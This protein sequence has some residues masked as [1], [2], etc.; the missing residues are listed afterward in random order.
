MMTDDEIL[1]A[2]RRTYAKGVKAVPIALFWP[3]RA[4][5]KQC[6]VIGAAL[7][8]MYSPSSL[9]E[10]SL[11][12]YQDIAKAIGRTKKFVIGCM[13]GFDDVDREGGTAAGYELGQRARCEFLEQS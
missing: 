10:M 5:P 8:D 7:F 6:C 2:A 9:C 11:D 4:E 3:S 13:E 12:E 1:A